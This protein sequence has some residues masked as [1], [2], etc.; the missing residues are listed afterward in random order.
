MC[1]NWGFFHFNRE[2][3]ESAYGFLCVWLYVATTFYNETWLDIWTI[4]HCDC[5]E[6]ILVKETPRITEILLEWH[7][8]TRSPHNSHNNTLNR[9]N[10]I[11]IAH[12]LIRLLI[13]TPHYMVFLTWH[14]VTPSPHN[15]HNN[16]LNKADVITIAHY[17][18]RLLIRTP[19]YMVFLTMPFLY[20]LQK[21]SIC[22][23]TCLCSY[24]ILR[25]LY[26]CSNF[27]LKYVLEDVCYTA[28]CCSLILI[29]WK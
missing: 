26:L 7:S 17:L 21:Y 29:S 27:L 4:C 3:D 14:S 2:P 1:N 6:T 11:T 18:I 13:R 16:T 25:V 28:A 12:Y 5:E 9:A 24:C 10:V 15:S 23:Y 22:A 19:H 8:V 20:T